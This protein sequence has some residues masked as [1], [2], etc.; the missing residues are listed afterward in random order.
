[1]CTDLHSANFALDAHAVE[2]GIRA[3]RGGIELE[4]DVNFRHQ[5]FEFCRVN[6]AVGAEK[7]VL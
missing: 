4:T 6:A 5:G 1:M 7:P 3:P 2:A